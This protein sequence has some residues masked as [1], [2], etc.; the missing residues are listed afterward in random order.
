[1]AV[2]D[3]VDPAAWFAEQLGA[4]EPDLLRSMVKTM[5]KALIS[6]ARL[7]EETGLPPS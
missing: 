5:A 7:L 2:S 4:C 1:M 6:A 3:N